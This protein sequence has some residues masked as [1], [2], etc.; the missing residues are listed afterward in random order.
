M[1]RLVSTLTLLRAELLKFGAV[2]AVGVVS[3]VV[4]SNILWHATGLTPTEAAVGGSGVA[5][6]TAYIGNRYWTFRDRPADNRRREMLLFALISAIGL[7]I[8]NGFVFSAD[9]LFGFHSKLAYNVA[10]FGFGLPVAGAFRFWTSHM[11]VFPDGEQRGRD[12]FDR[13]LSVGEDAGD[14]ATAEILNS[15]ENSPN[16]AGR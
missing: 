3:D 9:H 7:V 6:V 1:N 10:K 4:S 16:P 13:G 8:E 5:T 12:P 14:A 2:G 11:F 15:R